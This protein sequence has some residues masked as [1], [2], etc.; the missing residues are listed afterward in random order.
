MLT[1]R[2]EPKNFKEATTHD[3]REKW[4]EAMADEMNSLQDNDTYSNWSQFKSRN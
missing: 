1:N 2:G 3:H 4:F